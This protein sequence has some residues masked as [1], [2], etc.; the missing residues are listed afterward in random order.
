[1]AF[2]SYVCYNN[3]IIGSN[4]IPVFCNLFHLV[5][6]GLMY[7]SALWLLLNLYPCICFRYLL[8]L[9][10]ACMCIHLFIY[11]ECMVGEFCSA[12]SILYLIGRGPKSVSQQ[13]CNDLIFVLWL[14]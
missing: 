1:M 9:I 6:I 8:Y 14:T 3:Y 11:D 10:F 5:Y 13:C 7:I 12:K 4:A 2:V